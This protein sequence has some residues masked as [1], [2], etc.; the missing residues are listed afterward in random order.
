MGSA[1]RL[2]PSRALPMHGEGLRA[3]APIFNDNLARYLSAKKLRYVV[4]RSRGY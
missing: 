1:F 3:I 2:G 4:N